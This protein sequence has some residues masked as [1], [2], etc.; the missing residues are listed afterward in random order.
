MKKSRIILPAI[1]LLA[2]SGIASV[3]G[4]VAWFTASQSAAISVGN[5]AAINTAGDLVANIR[6]ISGIKTPNTVTADGNAPAE[7]ETGDYI[8]GKTFNLEY[9]RDC[10]YD[11]MNDEYH[12]ASVTNKAVDGYINVTDKVESKTPA[13]YFNDGTTKNNVCFAAVW[14]IDF[15]IDSDAFGEYELFFDPTGTK[16]KLS[17]TTE[18]GKAFR[19]AMVSDDETVIWAPQASTANENIPTKYVKM[20][21]TAPAVANYDADDFIDAAANVVYTSSDTKSSATG[22][23]YH[24]ASGLKADETTTVHFVAW[25][26]GSDKNCIQSNASNTE[27]DFD[28]LTL[29]ASFYAVTW[30][31]N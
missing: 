25:F 9:L 14:D 13:G 12:I 28:P 22:S 15:T 21:E 5:I 18:I 4:T 3:T 23:K 29:S 24:L 1:A 16:S 19:L 10:S 30:S 31:N 11:A 6:G 27:A 2:V 8:S 20:G 17:G 7:G 26:E